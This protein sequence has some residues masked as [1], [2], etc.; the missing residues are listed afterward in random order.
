MQVKG[1]RGGR[2]QAPRK[3]R[4]RK[5]RGLLSN[6]GN[7][8]LPGLGGGLGQIADNLVGGLIGGLGKRNPGRNALGGG[9]NY[10]PV[11]QAGRNISHQAHS[12]Q[13]MGEEQLATVRV[14]GGTPAGTLLLQFLLAGP[15]V[16]TR[17]PAM[18][19]LWTRTKFRHLSFAVTSSNPSSAGGNYTVGIDPDPVQSYASGP[20]LTDRIMALSE[21]GQANAWADN[22]VTMV[23][24]GE[25][26]YNRFHPSTASDAEIREF[27][28]GQFLMATTTEYDVDCEYVVRV[29]WD[30]EFFQ[31]DTTPTQNPVQPPTFIFSSAGRAYSAAATTGD[32]TVFTP[33]N[34][35]WN[36]I[37]PPGTYSM[38][39]SVYLPK[40]AGGS[41]PITLSS[42]TVTGTTT[43]VTGR[44]VPSPG[45]AATGIIAI[46]NPSSIVVT[47]ALALADQEPRFN[48]IQAGYAKLH[49]LPY[50][51]TSLQH[52][53]WFT[54][55]LVRLEAKADEKAVVAARHQHA[56]EKALKALRVSDLFED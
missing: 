8:V 15:T 49:V 1:K 2:R 9:L 27:A 19:N 32:T 26:L 36:T 43:V 40:T 12:S 46:Q 45:I 51:D 47:N 42:C 41:T 20:D 13:E 23:P 53:E 3:N 22:G 24:L 5:G 31:P 6:I 18:A 29:A 21:A 35:A 11:A 28:A 33:N 14:P 10:A 4:S 30:V 54:Q 48:L 50:R 25:H 55:N 44:N 16:G 37:P 38:N 34:A 7:M 39:G 17:L 56:I 52:A